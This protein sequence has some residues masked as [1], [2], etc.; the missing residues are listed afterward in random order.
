MAES[1][2]VVRIL[3]Y[4]SGT[5]YLCNGCE[6]NIVEIIKLNRLSRQTNISI[7]QHEISMGSLNA[8]KK[9]SPGKNVLC[10]EK[11]KNA[12]IRTIQPE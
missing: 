7:N 9:T 8:I 4:R 6:N 2:E 5:I 12:I 11:V 1:Y 3:K 10:R